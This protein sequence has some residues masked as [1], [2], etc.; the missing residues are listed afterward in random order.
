MKSVEVSYLVDISKILMNKYLIISVIGPHAGEEINQIFNRKKKEIADS[1]KSFWLIRSHKAT[2][3]KI[4]K[5]CKEGGIYCI[6]I[7][8]SRKSG[9]QDTK[10]ASEANQYSEDKI[11]W[12][13]IRDKIKVTGKIDTNATAL[14]FSSLERSDGSIN[15][16]D[17]S[18]FNKLGEPI[19]I[20]Q[21]AST[22]CCV[23]QPCS[24]EHEIKRM[25]SKNRKIAGF[26][27][28]IEPFGVWL[29]KI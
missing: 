17:Y 22:L 13:G 8:P 6:F 14:V 4:Q 9:S 11:K 23:K 24:K 25:K 5:I 10:N 28:L 2:S 15:L 26:G 20:M 18:D 16:W 29:R 7:E 19:K 12:S 1:G 27:R 3:D 21:G